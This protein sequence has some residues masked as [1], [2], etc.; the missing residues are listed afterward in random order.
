MHTLIATAALNADAKGKPDT[1]E[2]LFPFYIFLKESDSIRIEYV[3][4]AVCATCA[5]R[6]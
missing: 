5:N 6:V 2:S 4:K 1:W 3:N